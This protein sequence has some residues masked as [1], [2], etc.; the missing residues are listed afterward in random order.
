MLLWAPGLDAGECLRPSRCGPAAV[1]LP[2]F[3]THWLRPLLEALAENYK[4]VVRPGIRPGHSRRTQHSLASCRAVGER[5]VERSCGNPWGQ[6]SD[7]LAGG[8]VTGFIARS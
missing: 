8:E 5:S 6:D 7:I 1:S 2:S 4:S 3:H